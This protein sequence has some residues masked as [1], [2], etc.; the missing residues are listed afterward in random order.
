MPCA[1]AVGDTCIHA[2][3]TTVNHE[4]KQELSQ[5]LLDRRH[6]KL[7]D[8]TVTEKIHQSECAAIEATHQIIQMIRWKLKCDHH[9]SGRYT[10]CEHVSCSTDPEGMTYATLHD[11]VSRSESSSK[12]TGVRTMDYTLYGKRIRPISMS[13]EMKLN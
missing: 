8:L 4:F 6:S 9:K 11:K 10:S 3:S 2:V 1:C 13:H 5:R 7:L 12:A